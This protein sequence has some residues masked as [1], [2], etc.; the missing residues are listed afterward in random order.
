MPVE[1]ES[2]IRAS[3]FVVNREY[4]SPLPPPPPATHMVHVLRS[5]YGLNHGDTDLQSSCMDYVPTLLNRIEG[6]PE[7]YKIVQ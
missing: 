3:L 4:L 6:I 5:S 1:R 7:M 2:Y